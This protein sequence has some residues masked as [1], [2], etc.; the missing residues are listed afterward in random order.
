[1]PA[2]RSYT[3]VQFAQPLGRRKLTVRHRWPKKWCLYK[4]G[5]TAWSAGGLTATCK[6]KVPCQIL[7][8][9]C[10]PGPH[11]L[12]LFCRYNLSITTHCQNEPLL[13][14]WNIHGGY[15]YK[16]TGWGVAP[17]GLY[18]ALHVCQKK[19]LVSESWGSLP[20]SVVCTKTSGICQFS[21][22]T[23]PGSE[24]SPIG[25]E[26][27]AYIN[28]SFCYW[29][30]FILQGFAF[31][32]FTMSFPYYESGNINGTTIP[33]HDDAIILESGM[34]GVIISA[35]VY[36]GILALT[37][38]YIPLLLKTSNDISRRMRIFLLVYVVLMVAI[39]TVYIITIIVALTHSVFHPSSF[40][41]EVYLFQNRLA[42]ALCITFA[43]WGADGF[44]V[45]K[46]HKIWER[47]VSWLFSF[48][49]VR[50]HSSG[51]V[52]CYIRAFRDIVEYH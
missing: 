4:L 46:F 47:K 28:W 1:M 10:A 21:G 42:G 24:W 6:P 30:V 32:P 36:G 8:L 26:Y 37:L 34:I 13:G 18:T 11:L 20:K 27:N 40:Q 23:S 12:N 48:I 39:S 49:I 29:L 52:Q 45:S 41:S 44:M 2:I 19:T 51:D 16:A 43:S 31:N 14:F 5:I 9:A 25:S 7:A 35:I 22:T 38:S 3:A 17:L 50:F 15:P 33:L